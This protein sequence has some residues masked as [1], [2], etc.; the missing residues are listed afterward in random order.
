MSEPDKPR[1]IE[2]KVTDTTTRLQS[3]KVDVRLDTL[4]SKKTKAKFVLLDHDKILNVRQFMLTEQFDNEM[5]KRYG[6]TGLRGPA[7]R[8]FLKVSLPVLQFLSLKVNS[9][10]FALKSAPGFGMRDFLGHFCQKK[11]REN[12]LEAVHA[13]AL[14]DYQEALA[15]Q[16]DIRAKYVRRMI[17]FW[18][19][20]TM[21]KGAVGWVTT[22]FPLRIGTGD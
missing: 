15:R 12:V 19:I 6:T 20:A 16:D 5:K 2:R 13:E 8:A 17:Y 22:K 11:F 3:P 21:L 4:S 7:F 9:K 14:V 1:Q 10:N 18:M